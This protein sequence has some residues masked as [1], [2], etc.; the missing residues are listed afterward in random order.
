MPRISPE[1]IRLSCLYGAIF[2]VN[3]IQLPFW[4]IWL[5]SRGM[6][7]LE[8]G[9]LS[10]ALYWAKAVTNPTIGTIIDARGNR[11]GMMRFLAVAS[12][13]ISLLYLGVDGFW[14]LLVIGILGGSLFSGITPVAETISMDHAMRGKI[15][16]GRV[17]LWGSLSFMASAYVVGKVL[18]YTPNNEVILW[19][20]L[21]GL[22][23]TVAS[24]WFSPDS[25]HT[26]S[27]AKREA[28]SSLLG[29]RNFL[30]FLVFAACAQGSH[31]VYYAFGSLHWVSQGVESGVIG[32]LWAVGVLAEIIL[33]AFSAHFMRRVDPTI[34]M[35]SAGVAGIIRWPLMAMT[36]SLPVL[37]L[38]QILH[39]FTFGAAH[40]AAMHYITA[41]TRPG[42]IARAQTIYSAVAVGLGSGLLMIVA[43]H[44]YESFSGWAY[45]AMAGLSAL[46]L[47]SA[48]TLAIA[49]TRLTN[50]E[51]KKTA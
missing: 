37:V 16:Y 3:G 48:A 8:I 10:G 15:D 28:W 49:R 5:E 26:D 40:L 47:V 23:I 7:P 38:L 36:A 51:A 35:V 27:N 21:G 32:T 42:L 43:G 50:Q 34:L 29:D 46:A 20:F 45:L 19:M 6:G 41:N 33:F 44:L 4:P 39:A 18:D 17:R 24:T 13:V 9:I 14:G 22:G 31:A 30:V 2:V 11:V 1:F 25:P 12:L